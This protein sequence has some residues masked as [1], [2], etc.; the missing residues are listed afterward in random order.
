MHV[1]S[2]AFGTA[3]VLLR[4]STDTH[5]TSPRIVVSD[6]INNANVY[7]FRIRHCMCSPYYL[8]LSPDA[9]NCVW[10]AVTLSVQV[11]LLI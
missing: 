11:P 4:V 1:R 6:N 9:E 3:A 2:H 5:H 7:N 10:L 8:G